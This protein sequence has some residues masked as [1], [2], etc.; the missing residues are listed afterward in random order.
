MFRSWCSHV[1][2]L[3]FSP[4]AP[5]H[6][7]KRVA[8]TIYIYLYLLW[9]RPPKQIILIVFLLLS[10]TKLFAQDSL[11][12]SH[13]PFSDSTL[14]SFDIASST[15]VSII[16]YNTLGQKVDSLYKDTFLQSG[17]YAFYLGADLP[18]GI[19]LVSYKIN[20][21]T[22][23]YQILK[24]N[25]VSKIDL[26]ST[27]KN[28]IYIFPNPC[29]GNL[30]IRFEHPVLKPFTIDIYDPAGRLVY[31]TIIFNSTMALNISEFENGLYTL[32]IPDLGYSTQL[33][34]MR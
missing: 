9:M 22:K 26:T 4:T 3:V 34:L 19:F 13:N 6:I 8:Q 27:Q 28:S 17:S 24:S 29:P 7:K 1:P 15:K 30:N 23:N 21:T 5:F 2:Q 11:R 14:V 20:S 12:F 10:I 33:V 18:N 31:T 25:L 32:H 16:V